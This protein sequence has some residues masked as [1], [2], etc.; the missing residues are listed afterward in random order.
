MTVLDPE[1][2]GAV[3]AEQYKFECINEDGDVYETFDNALDAM[4]MLAVFPNDTVRMSVD[5]G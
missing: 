4:Y 5:R 1:Q 3:I 2:L